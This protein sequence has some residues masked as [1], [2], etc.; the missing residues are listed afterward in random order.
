MRG[1]LW[2]DRAWS[3]QRSHRAR[4]PPLPPLCPKRRHASGTSLVATSHRP[5]HCLETGHGQQRA[6][7]DR[8]GSMLAQV[9]HLAETPCYVCRSGR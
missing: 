2:P 9:T 4:L 3:A 7:S 5:R 8:P 1:S 6:A